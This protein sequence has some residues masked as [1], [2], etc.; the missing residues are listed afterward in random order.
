MLFRFVKILL[1]LYVL[2]GA[3]VWLT[4][5]FAVRT[6]AAEPL[7]DLGYQLSDKSS[8]RLNLFRMNISIAELSLQDIKTNTEYLRI[9]KAEVNL[10]AP[11][12]LSKTIELE[13]IHF[14]DLF[15]AVKRDDEKLFVAGY[16]INQAVDTRDQDKTDTEERAEPL[17]WDI[18]LS[19]FDL[20][21]FETNFIDNGENHRLLL[22]QFHL[23]DITFTS[24]SLVGKTLAQLNANINESSITTKIGYE[25]ENEI[26]R[27]SLDTKISNLQAKDFA[28]L[29]RDFVDQASAKIDIT[30]KSN[31]ELSPKNTRITLDDLSVKLASANIVAQGFNYKHKTLEL[32]SANT[33]IDIGEGGAS[34]AGVQ[35]NTVLEGA[36]LTETKSQNLLFSLSTLETP[37]VKV[38]IQSNEQ[39]TAN[40]GQINLSDFQASEPGQAFVTEIGEITLPSL[41][42]FKQL[43]IEGVNITETHTNIASILLNGLDIDLAM[44]GEQGLINLVKVGGEESAEKAPQQDNG[45]ATDQTEKTQAYTFALGKFGLDSEATIS[46]INY[47][48]APP[49]TYDFTVNELALDD[50][51]SRDQTSLT[52]LALDVTAGQYANVAS[53][54]QMAI[55]SDKLTGSLELAITEFSLPPISPFIREP[56]GFDMLAGQLDTTLSFKIEQDEV[57]GNTY[58]KMRALELSDA[59]GVKTDSLAEGAPIPLNIALLALKDSSGAIELDVPMKGNIQDPDFG[60]QGFFNLIIN[61]AVLLGGQAYLMTTVVPY[62][63]VV[64]LTSIAADIALKDRPDALIYA[65]GQIE[66]NDSQKAHIKMIADLIA[67][68]DDKSLKLCPFATEKD[69][70]NSNPE[71]LKKYRKATLLNVAQKRGAALK[72]YLVNNHQAPSSLLMVCQAFLDSSENPMPRVDFIY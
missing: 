48:A 40:I 69:G 70:L 23:E 17:G 1:G 61:R 47:N 27:L 20:V 26:L 56:L 44:L 68:N 31:I 38:D 62:G 24:G 53:N 51:D 33:S 45:E 35:F 10:N 25:S 67:K 66:I 12:L 9:D 14:E 36:E 21:R 52:T 63:N 15:L 16:E 59:E 54:S 2:I 72:D 13:E 32:S 11:G 55:F 22:D 43:K 37:L 6:F 42:E 71:A 18:I 4:T 64:A 39:F 30:L 5:P 57:E 28:Y 49:Q 8:V 34:I 7:K 46:L 29:A 3:L 58:I 50:I 19:T 60:L 41:A 65:P